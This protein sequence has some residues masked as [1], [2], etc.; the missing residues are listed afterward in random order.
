MRKTVFMFAALV[1]FGADEPRPKPEVE[2]PVLTAAD[3]EA[4]LDAQNALKDDQLQVTLGEAA[5]LRL[6]DRRKA[7]DAAA[8]ALQDKCGDYGLARDEAGHIQC[9]K[10]KHTAPHQ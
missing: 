7:V 6:A 4:Y 3:R 1:A 5:A 2:A 10:V 8:K 9:G